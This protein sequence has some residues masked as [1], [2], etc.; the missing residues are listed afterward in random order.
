MAA[1]V[2]GLGVG[3]AARVGFGEPEGGV[4]EQPAM[5]TEMATAVRIRLFMP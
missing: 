3:L 4:L 1:P 2:A 5:N